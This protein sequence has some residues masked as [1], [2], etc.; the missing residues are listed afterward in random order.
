[1]HPEVLRDEDREKRKGEAETE[2]GGEL[3]EPQGGEIALPVDR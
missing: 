2:D 3:G 1:V